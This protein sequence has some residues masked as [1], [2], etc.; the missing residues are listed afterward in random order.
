[1][2][3]DAHR[4]DVSTTAAATPGSTAALPS[5]GHPTTA[6]PPTR[7]TADSSDLAGMRPLPE[8]I[9]VEHPAKLYDF[10]R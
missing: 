8:R 1:M 5:S 6:M 3:T 10:P 2:V 4:L 9:L 7:G